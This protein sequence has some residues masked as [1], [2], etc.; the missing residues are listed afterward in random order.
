MQL[1]W[2]TSNAAG[3]GKKKK[4]QPFEG[5]VSAHLESI[6]RALRIDPKSDQF[7]EN[8]SRKKIGTIEP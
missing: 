8:K 6:C 7:L 4:Q 5:Q 1:W 3:D 2:H